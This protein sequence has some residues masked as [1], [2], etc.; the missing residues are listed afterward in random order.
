MKKIVDVCCGP[1]MMWFDKND[2]RVLFLDKRKENHKT[3][4]TNIKYD[5]E[6][7]NLVVFD[8][9]HIVQ[10]SEK[11]QIIKQYGRLIPGEWKQTIQK[12]FSECFRILKS[13]GVLIFKWNECRIPVKEIL[14]LTSEKPLFGHKSGKHLNTHWICFMKEPQQ[15]DGANSTQQRLQRH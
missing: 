15:T 6:T 2:E 12:G 4:F 8:P 5:D 14:E 11:G 13:N 3:N 7:F 9:P 10:N 1:K